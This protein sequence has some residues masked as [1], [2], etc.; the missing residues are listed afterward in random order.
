MTRACGA[1]FAGMFWRKN[2]PAIDKSLPLAA[3]IRRAPRL[4]AP[5]AAKKAVAELLAD[6]DGAAANSLKRLF[7]Q[8]PALR[9]I[10]GIADGSPFLWGLIREDPKRFAELLDSIPN[11]ILPA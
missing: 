9:L 5:K 6:A 3:R 4:S 2:K 7:E 1:Q 8:K 11:R 10:E